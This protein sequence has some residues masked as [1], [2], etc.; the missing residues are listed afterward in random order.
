MAER[1]SVAHA[2]P[3][4]RPLRRG[5]RAGHQPTHRRA[6]DLADG[7]LVQKKSIRAAAQ[8]SEAVQHERRLFADALAEI[9]GERLIYVDESGVAPGQRLGYGYARRGERAREA[10]PYRAPGRVNL[11]GAIGLGCGAVQSYPVNVRAVIFE[12]FVSTALVPLLT[13]AS[14]V[15]WDN[16]RVHSEKARAMV[17]AV[18][19]RVLAQPRYSPDMNAIELAWSKVKQSVRT[20]RADTPAALDAAL[21]TAVASVSEGDLA[22]WI[23]HV[24]PPQPN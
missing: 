14:V 22:G 16:A 12:H 4:R 19:A 11:I 23:R 20:S 2:A 8:D 9:V 10:A 24:R 15:V 3:P 1:E 17:E 7:I 13:S 5:D 6:H 21:A 18:G